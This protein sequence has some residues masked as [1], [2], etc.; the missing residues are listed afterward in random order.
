MQT[1]LKQ[2]LNNRLEYKYWISDYFLDD[3]RNDMLPYM[4]YDPYAAIRPDKHYTV[5]SI[6]IDTRKLRS[7]YEK[8]DGIR[9]RNKFR[10]RGYNDLE[11]DSSVFLEIKQKNIDF[12]SKTRVKTSFSDYKELLEC[13][14]P[15][16]IASF[17]DSEIRKSADKFIF[18]YLSE[19]LI[20]TANV[21]YDR[22]AFFCNYASNLRISFDKSI[23]TRYPESFSDIYGDHNLTVCRPGY[24]VIEIKF[25]QIL[26]AWVPAIVAK[27]KLKR[28]AISKYTLCVDTLR[29][30]HSLLTGSFS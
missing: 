10:I 27:Y 29:K 9:Y 2:E 1:K 5:R 19:N 25:Y 24:T 4:S 18:H 20:P 15:D 22:E 30:Q 14:N 26:P 17:S 28:E 12:I 16:Q 3:F 23:R 11:K 13:W 8:L 21:T 7:Y 6:Y